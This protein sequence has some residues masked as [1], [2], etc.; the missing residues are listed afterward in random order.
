[1][2]EMLKGRVKSCNCG[3]ECVEHCDCGCEDCAC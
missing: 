2:E 3:C 1:M